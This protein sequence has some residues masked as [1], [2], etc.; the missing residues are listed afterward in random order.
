MASVQRKHHDEV[1]ALNSQGIRDVEIAER[2]GISSERV[3]QIR[4][5]LGLP[6]VDSRSACPVCGELFYLGALR[7]TCSRA[8]WEID[9]DRRC[10]SETF[11]CSKCKQSLARECF[12]KSR[13]KRGLN[14]RCKR[15]K[16]QDARLYRN[17]NRATE[18]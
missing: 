17:K 15:C 9:V 16:A 10:A 6:K 4:N 18:G 1:R 7:K 13:G 12:S 8:C 5:R 2:L 14:S 11:V 3:R